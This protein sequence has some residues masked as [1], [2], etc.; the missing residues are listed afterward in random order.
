MEVHGVVEDLPHFMGSAQK[1]MVMSHIPDRSLPDIDLSLQWVLFPR[2]IFFGSKGHKGIF[3]SRNVR[4]YPLI[5]DGPSDICNCWQAFPVRSIC[6]DENLEISVRFVKA[7]NKVHLWD[8]TPNYEILDVILLRSDGRN[9]E[10]AARV[11]FSCQSANELQ[12][13]STC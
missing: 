1:L 3:R 7:A 5:P 4:F 12:C 9:V 13:H 2:L 6:S 8:A 11:T 10:I